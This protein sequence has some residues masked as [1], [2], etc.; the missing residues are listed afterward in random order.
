MSGIF[1][2]NQTLARNSAADPDDTLNT[3]RALGALGYYEPPSFGM[4]EYPDE[5]DDIKPKPPGDQHPPS[6][7]EKPD[8]DG[9]KNPYLGPCGSLYAKLYAASQALNDANRA[10][11]EAQHNVKFTEE[12]I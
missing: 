8:D 7:P 5:P 10:H 3:K 6:A 1:N 9:N 11:F 4:T 2:L 12:K